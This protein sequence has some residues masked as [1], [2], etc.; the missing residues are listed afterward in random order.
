L[1]LRT[2][3]FFAAL[4]LH[5][6][7]TFAPTPRGAIHPDSSPLIPGDEDCSS[8]ISLNLVGRGSQLRNP[9]I[10]VRRAHDS[11]FKDLLGTPPE[12]RQN[13]P[14]VSIRFIFA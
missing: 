14:T 4:C 12:R 9:A 13:T 1:V 5:S 2:N 7:P 3:A 11:L 10:S 6:Q 8:C